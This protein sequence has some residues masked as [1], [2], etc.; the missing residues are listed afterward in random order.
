MGPAAP[1]ESPSARPRRVSPG[2]VLTGRGTRHPRPALFPDF[3]RAARGGCL[4]TAGPTG[5]DSGRAVAS[6]SL[7][8]LPG[9]VGQPTPPR[10][11]LLPFHSLTLRSPS[12]QAVRGY[13]VIRDG[14]LVRVLARAA[15]LHRRAVFSMSS[16]PA[17][18]SWRPGLSRPTVREGACA[19]RLPQWGSGGTPTREHAVARLPS[20]AIASLFMSPFV[21]AYQSVEPWAFAS[22]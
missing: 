20:P 19:R 1:R 18:M 13:C 17:Q 6:P 8:S 9:G 5:R 12:R 2:A 22:A 15:C 4:A 21:S 3:W 10:R 11:P 16:L 14:T 7:R